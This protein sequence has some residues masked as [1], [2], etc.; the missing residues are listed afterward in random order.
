MLEK[1]QL[2]VQVVQKLGEQ[3]KC[4]SSHTSQNNTNKYIKII[5]CGMTENKIV[6][7]KNRLLLQKNKNNDVFLF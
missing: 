5:V 6:N 7:S 2:C 4:H 1:N 3:R